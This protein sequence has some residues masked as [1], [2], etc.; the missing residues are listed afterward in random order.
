[1]DKFLRT[2]L[3]IL[4]IVV[5]ALLLFNL[6]VQLYWMAAGPT[7][8]GFGFAGGGMMA[9]RGGMHLFGGFG[10]LGPILG[11]ALVGLIVAG[12]AA[13][14]RGRGEGPAVAPSDSGETSAAARK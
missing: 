6:G 3:L 10:F 2:G 11:I 13:L 4:G 5:L 1:M 12:I 8:A 9:G 7:M 14:V